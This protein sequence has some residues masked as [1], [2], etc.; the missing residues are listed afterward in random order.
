MD[1]KEER[2]IITPEFKKE[3]KSVLDFLGETNTEKI[4]QVITEELIN[5]IRES[6]NHEW[7]V[8]PEIITDIVNEL[9]EECKQEIA[10]QFKEKISKEI[11]KQLVEKINTN[12]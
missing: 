1:N 3:V 11:V 10:K 4:K 2:T 6:I 12:I 9:A 5:N 8:L 7:I